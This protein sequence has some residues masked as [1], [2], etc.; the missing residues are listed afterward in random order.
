M[1]NKII[2]VI[3]VLVLVWSFSACNN[4]T[5]VFYDVKFNS[6][7]S[8]STQPD[9]F[10]ANPHWS[11]LIGVTHNTGY[12]MWQAGTLASIGMEQMAETGGKSFLLNEIEQAIS[13]GT[14]EFKISGPGMGVS[15]GSLT[16]SIKVNKSHP[17]VSLVAML[18][19]SPDWFAGVTSLNLR[20]GGDWVST[21]TVTLYTYDAGTD[22]GTTYGSANS[23]TS[24]KVNIQQIGTSPFFVS[25]V[26]T[27][28]GTF[29]FIRN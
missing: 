22:D 26:V 25:G 1:L 16:M 20:E 8:A 17:Y 2:K 14:G 15:P 12:T 5:V 18:A 4:S 24:P 6:T 10:P 23:D 21:K 28:V 29:T 9:S 19:P 7:W 27:P 13:D 3:V 11:G